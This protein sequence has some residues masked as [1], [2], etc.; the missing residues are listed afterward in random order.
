MAST[1]P[2]SDKRG[3]SIASLASAPPAADASTVGERRALSVFAVLAFVG[4]AW[5]AKPVGIGILLGALTAFALQPLYDRLCAY[6]RR[7]SFAAMGCVLV[8]A[9]GF[10]ATL[11]GLSYLLV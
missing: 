3:H 7:S 5:I 2:I 4:I 1:P 8:S 10:G 6:T 9:A 11:G